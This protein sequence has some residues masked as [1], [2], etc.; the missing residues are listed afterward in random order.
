[1]IAQS[2][3][4][5]EPQTRKRRDP[6]APRASLPAH[7]P[8]IEVEIMPEVNECPCCGGVLHRI[9]EDRAER[10]DVLPAQYRVLVTVRPKLGSGRPVTA[11]PKRWLPDTSFRAACPA[12]D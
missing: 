8:R 5:A 7:L 6:E 1:L 12:S 2:K 10:L 9:G 3:D 11:L 4:V